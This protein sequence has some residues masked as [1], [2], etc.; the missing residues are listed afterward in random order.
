MAQFIQPQGERGSLKWIQLAV[1]QKPS[2]LI[3]A[4][5]LRRLD[6]ATSINWLSPL[7][8]H[9]Y[10]EFRDEAFLAEIGVGHLEKQL[11]EFWP[12]RG[13][14]WDA[15]AKSNADDV[16]L[17]E[18]KAHI[19]ELC[20]PPSEASP[21]SLEL[22]DRALHETALFLGAEPKV[23]WTIMFYQLTNRLAHLHFLR[24][25]RIK[26]WLVLANFIGDGEMKG[27][28]SA[29]EWAAAY[30]VVWH[31]LGLSRKHRL[32]RF[33]VELCPDVREF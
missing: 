5:I 16:L 19:G 32:S 11:K 7:A 28:N 33:V 18:A 22:I 1:N 2:R 24:K 9:N 17:V 26:A 3:D 8:E 13:P 27:P 29:A 6:G 14:Q 30:H 12:A 15:L 21:A 10:A 31:V 4:L 23:P 20:S 25:N